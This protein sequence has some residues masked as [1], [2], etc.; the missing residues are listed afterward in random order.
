MI[1]LSENSSK[2]QN[3][4]PIIVCTSSN[5]ISKKSICVKKYRESKSHL[6]EEIKARCTDS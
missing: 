6:K 1:L 5:K 4:F 2:N 3:S